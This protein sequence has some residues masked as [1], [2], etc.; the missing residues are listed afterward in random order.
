MNHDVR[1][2]FPGPTYDHHDVGFG[3][4]VLNSYVRM[5]IR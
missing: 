2:S 1:D 4:D 3:P 5:A